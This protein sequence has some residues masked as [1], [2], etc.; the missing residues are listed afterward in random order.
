MKSIAH[1][2]SLLF[3]HWIRRSS[4]KELSN[5]IGLADQSFRVVFA[6]KERE[7]MLGIAV[8]YC[9]VTNHPKNDFKLQ[10]LL[11]FIVFWVLWVVHWAGTRGK[12]GKCLGHN[13]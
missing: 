10:L 2:E 13:I 6:Q 11:W 9:C 1:V 12:Q 3:I 8:I 5:L 4:F 7:I